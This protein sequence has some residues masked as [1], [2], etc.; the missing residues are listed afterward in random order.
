MNLKFSNITISGGVAVGKSTLINNLISYLSPYGWKFKS[1]GEIHREFLKDNVMPEATKVTDD[2]DR[3]IESKVEQ[4]LQTE[5]KW[6]IQAWLSGFIARNIPSTLRVLLICKNN[7]LRV[8]R[9]ANRDNI[10][11]DEAKQFISKRELGNLS[12]YK[13]LYG[14]YDFWDPK[15]YHLV[16]DTYSSGQLETVGKVL[17]KLGFLITKK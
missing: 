16:I 15:Y 11:V 6:I 5:K 9:V 17:D 1:V 3:A 8:D 14:D 7:S 4:I 10:T 2:F 12:K 13:R